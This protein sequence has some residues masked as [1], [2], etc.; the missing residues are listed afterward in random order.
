MGNKAEINK[1]CV[2][3]RGPSGR[4]MV[5]S[6]GNASIPAVDLRQQVGFDRLFSTQIKDITIKE[7]MLF[8]K[9]VAGHRVG[10]EQWGALAMARQGKDS[11]QIISYYYPLASLKAVSV[12]L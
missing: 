9:A 3:K 7:T 11:Q 1:I 2:Q 10:M 6:A 5:I 12:I 8:L 4:A